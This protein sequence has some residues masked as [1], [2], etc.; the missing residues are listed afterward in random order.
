MFWFVFG[1]GGLL[2]YLLVSKVL[3]KF[4][5]SGTNVQTLADRIPKK[6]WR[7]KALFRCIE[8]LDHQWIFLLFFPICALIGFFSSIPILW[9]LGWINK[10]FTEGP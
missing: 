5:K 6:N 10:F 7:T 2:Y 9:A 1:V 4:D 8:S 3:Y